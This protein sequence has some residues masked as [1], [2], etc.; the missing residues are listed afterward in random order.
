MLRPSLWGLLQHAGILERMYS[1]SLWFKPRRTPRSRASSRAYLQHKAAARALVLSRIQHFSQVYPYPCK[2]IAIRNQKTRWGSCSKQ[3]GLNFNYRL[4][5][6]PLHLADYVIVHELCHLAQ[7]N[8]SRA[9]WD[10]VAQAVPDYKERRA[11][12]RALRMPH[13][14]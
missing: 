4:A 2:G 7:F 10:L 6:L 5:L 9:F 8:H 14:R 12:L 1:I 11:E 13:L 3:G